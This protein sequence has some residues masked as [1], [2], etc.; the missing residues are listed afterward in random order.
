MQIMPGTARDLGVTD[1]FDPRE[2][3]L[4]G[5]CYLKKLLTRFRGSIPLALAAYNAGPE[6]VGP[7]RKVPDIEETQCFVRKVTDY[8]YSY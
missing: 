1:S 6:R 4:G 3:I 2:N 5:V 8:F 7:L